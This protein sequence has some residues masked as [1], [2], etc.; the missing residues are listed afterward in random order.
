MLN[1]SFIKFTGLQRKAREVAQRQVV[2][3]GCHWS[4]RCCDPGKAI[5]D[6]LPWHVMWKYLL[7]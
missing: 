4:Y 7:S 5:I 6:G 2:L 1:L 3:C